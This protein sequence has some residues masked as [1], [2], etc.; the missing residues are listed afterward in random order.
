MSGIVGIFHRDGAHIERALLRSLVDFLAY[1][2]PDGRSSWVGTSIGL[3]HALLRVKGDSFQGSQP[4]TLDGRYWIT[5]DVRLDCRTELIGK[6]GRLATDYGQSVPDSEL[7]LRAYAKWGSACVEQLR[8]DF[9]FAIW[10]AVKEQL[11]CARDH[12]GIKPFYYANV[13]SLLVFSNSLDC[14]RRHPA[15]SERLNDLAIADFLLFDMIREPGAT[16]FVDI[17][18]LR[19]AHTLECRRSNVSARRYWV[20]PVSAPIYQ[21]RPRECVEQFR[22]LLDRAVADRLR[23]DSVAVFMTG[24]LDSSTVAASAQR[25]LG[26]PEGV[27][28]YTEVFD[29]LIPHEERRYAM[30]VAKAL[31]IPIEFHANE[32]KLS[33]NREHHHWPEPVHLPGSDGGLGQMREA[34]ARNSV[35]LTGYGA[36]PALSCLLS[37]HFSHLLK[38]GQLGRALIE[39][40]RYLAA[41]GRFSRLYLRTRWR[42][43]FGPKSQVPHYPVWL[44]PDLERRFGLRERWDTLNRASTPNRAVRPVSYRAIVDPLWPRLFEGFDSGFTHVPME[45]RHPF[46]DLRLLDFLLALPALPWCSDKELLREAAR[47]ILPDV[48]RLRRKSPLLADPLV[49]VLQQPESAWVD[50]FESVPELGHYVERRLIPKVFREKDAWIAWSHLRPL[51]L[52]YW[53]RLRSRF[54]ISD[55]GVIT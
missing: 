33:K 47:G 31:K 38:K 26:L 19:P 49:A 4:A 28:A 50:S 11:F 24:G 17:Q 44:N 51:S 13:G 43:R 42:R 22:E 30:L 16:S 34:A 41:E 20:L 48:V 5:A 36:D 6:L 7:I 10:D 3:G 1:R 45:V 40:I 55:K 9:S 2:G 29:S 21:R 35:A 18:R 14:V 54:A 53:L 37:V 23:T 25:T 8:G 15:I 27:F 46:F 39:A 52:N 32:M 12:L